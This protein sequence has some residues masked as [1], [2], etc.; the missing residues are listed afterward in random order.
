MTHF[1]KI[2]FTAFVF[3]SYAAAAEP[4]KLL[5]TG[6]IKGVFPGADIKITMNETK[7]ANPL[8]I[9][10]CFWEAS[11]TDMKFVQLTIAEDSEAKIKTAYQF[12]NN[13]QYIE[14]VKDV[15][16]IGKSAYYGGSG[17]KMGAGLHV[18]IEGA[19]LNITVGLGIGNK[20]EQKHIDIEKAL[21]AKAIANLQKGK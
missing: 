11:E 1:N 2:F 17:L 10:R 16:G 5:D 3:I 4:C 18:R 19:W 21:A 15:A 13:K 20:D 12:D 9:K 6:D 8:G 14:N 7:P